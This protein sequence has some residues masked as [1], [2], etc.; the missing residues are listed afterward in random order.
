MDNLTQ[1]FSNLLR[2]SVDKPEPLL[3]RLKEIAVES[4]DK[5]S[6]AESLRDALVRTLIELGIDEPQARRYVSAALLSCGIR[7]RA[8]GAGPKRQSL[9]IK[10]R[11]VSCSSAILSIERFFGVT[12]LE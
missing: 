1:G 7:F 6:D 8:S 12:T 9:F 2:D 10:G 11:T 5:G 3:H 4:L